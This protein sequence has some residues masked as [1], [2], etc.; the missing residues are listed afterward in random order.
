MK[1]TFTFIV[2]AFMVVS[3]WSF[4]WDKK[5]SRGNSPKDVFQGIKGKVE[6][7]VAPKPETIRAELKKKWEENG[8]EGYDKMPWGTTVSEFLILYPKAE[9]G[10]EGCLEQYARYGS[11][12]NVILCY[13]FYKNELVSGITL[14]KNL[15]EE[16]SIEDINSRMVELYGNPTD[17]KNTSE[18]K[19]RN[20]TDAEIALAN[21]ALRM[22][23]LPYRASRKQVNYTEKHSV[24][25]WSNSKSFN[26]VSDLCKLIGD[27]DYDTVDITLYI[28]SNTQNMTIVYENP[29]FKSQIEADNKKLEQEKEAEEKRKAEEEKRRRL[30]SL[31]L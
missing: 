31:D 22:A 23:N 27:T 18:H 15:K 9:H 12:D 29:E 4:P 16:T 14:Y 30:D 25:T 17:T 13:S 8:C 11:S 6:D 5:G 2:M 21:E 24:K 7:K 10:N 1:K 19:V 20:V 28:T 3:A 26:M